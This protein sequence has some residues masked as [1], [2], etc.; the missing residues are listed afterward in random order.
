MSHLAENLSVA[1]D[2]TLDTIRRAVRVVRCICSGIALPIGILERHLTICKQLLS[3]LLAHHELT[4]A[5]AHGNRVQVANLE[6]REPRRC[7]SSDTGRNNLRNVAMNIVVEQRRRLLGHHTQAAVRQQARLNQRLETVADTENQTSTL[8]Q[9]VN[10]LCYGCIVQYAGNKLTAT[11]R[12]ISERESST[13]NEDMTLV[14]SRSHCVNRMKNILRRKVTEY[15]DMRLG[16][17]TLECASCII[18]A[19]CTREYREIDLHLLNLLPLILWSS[20]SAVALTT[21]LARLALSRVD[22]LELCG[23]CLVQLCQRELLAQD[24][25]ALLLGGMSYQNSALECKRLDRLNENRSIRVI[26]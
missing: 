24:L 8:N 26:E 23:I 5:V 10:G 6:R 1:R 20:G 17:L 11:I 2:D 18:V 13:Q 21:L 19:V 14:D 16:T 3:H 22:L 12:L 7:S 25:N 9:S 15:S 4:L